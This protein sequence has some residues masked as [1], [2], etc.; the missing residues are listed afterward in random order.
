MFVV[1]VCYLLGEFL[2]IV[3]LDD[4]NSMMEGL[5][6]FSFE[7][8]VV[9]VCIDSDGNVVMKSGDWY[10]E[11]FIMKIGEFVDVVFDK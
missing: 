11:S 8:Y 7:L 3:V 4:N 1:V 6:L 9:C 5:K 10:V 2:R